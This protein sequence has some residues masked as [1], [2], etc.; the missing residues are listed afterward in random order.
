[1]AWPLVAGPGGGKGCRGGVIPRKSAGCG[2]RWPGNMDEGGG[3]GPK[4]HRNS[5]D[6]LDATVNANLFKNFGQ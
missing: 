3:R 6:Q 4:K 1:M 5:K 2:L